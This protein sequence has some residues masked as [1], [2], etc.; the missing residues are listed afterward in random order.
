[1]STF[2]HAHFV[3]LEPLCPVHVGT[4]E[5]L[6]PLSYV[7]REE[8]GEPYLYCVDLGA[9]VEDYP[10]PEELASFF[11]QRGL[12]EIRGR[13]SQ[14]IP[15]EV[16]GR[17]RSK[18]ASRALWKKYESD[19]G[20]RQSESQLLMAPCTRSAMTGAAMIPGSAVKGALR[21][22]VTDWADREFGLR[23]K[24]ASQKDGKKAVGREYTGRLESVFGKIGN[25]VFKSLKVGDFQAG[26]EGS[27]FVEATEVSKN[28]Q[29]K[30][31]TPKNPCEVIPGL[32]MDDVTALFGRIMLGSAL[33]GKYDDALEL[34][35]RRLDLAEI[36]R[37]CNAF[38][39]KRFA[40][41]KAK[42]YAQP[43]LRETAV[44]MKRIEDMI[45][46]PEPGTCVL[47]VGHYSHVECVTVSENA[48]QTR[49]DK[50]TRTQV[51]HGTTRTL[52]NGVFP[53]GWIRLRLCGETEWHEGD[54]R[55]EQNDA[56]VIRARH[57]ARQQL[58]ERQ[59]ALEMQR[60][61][62]ERREREQK[63]EEERRQKK[64]Q[65]MPEDERQ[66]YLLESGQLNENQV[67]EVFAALDSMSA[68]MK[69]RAAKSFKALWQ[70]EGKWTKKECSKKQWAK[71][72]KVKSILGE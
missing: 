2:S 54:I 65:A 59:E 38:Y 19:L 12:P 68:E 20:A 62:R 67:V 27:V 35:G 55:R 1:M 63:L 64:L 5:T 48:P 66:V 3:Q 10:E 43:H 72:G 58:V 23:L 31:S 39:A 28:P 50:R 47:R 46:N 7:I 26:L 37:I 49:F 16:Y 13:V 53:F 45:L 30:N 18:V 21:T 14:E 56:K 44:A 4:G 71:V 6:D 57:A 33:G 42:F 29:R 11:S 9:W 17:T 41:E 8:D 22:A 25:S 52:A 15:V 24:E 51:P 70:A 40:E 61:E 36:M 32:I 60:E 69:Q 34:R